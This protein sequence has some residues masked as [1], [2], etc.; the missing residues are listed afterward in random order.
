MKRLVLLFSLFNLFV[1]SCSCEGG[2]YCYY[3]QPNG[4]VV[5]FKCDGQAEVVE[6]DKEDPVMSDGGPFYIPWKWW[7][8]DAGSSVDTDAGADTDG[9]TGTDGSVGQD[10]GD[11]ADTDAGGDAGDPL[12]N[13]DGTDDGTDDGSDDGSGDD[14]TDDGDQ[15]DGDDDGSDDN[16]CK[17]KVEIVKLTGTH[18]NSG[19][20][21][22]FTCP[23]RACTGD[24]EGDPRPK[25]LLSVCK[26]LQ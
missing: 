5:E 1:V 11:G 4:D 20:T 22:E 12:G 7:D 6:D 8:Y 3:V 13:D 19:K 17:C 9:A 24:C 15:G 18:P 14:G 21:K 23:F 2:T 26:R 10:A 16:Q 25:G